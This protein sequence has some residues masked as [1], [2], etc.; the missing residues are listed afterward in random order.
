M[1]KVMSACA[2]KGYNIFKN[3]WEKYGNVKLHLSLQAS[4]FIY[5]CKMKAFR[6]FGKSMFETEVTLAETRFLLINSK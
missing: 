1:G 6:T 4:I 2:L 5:Y 3:I